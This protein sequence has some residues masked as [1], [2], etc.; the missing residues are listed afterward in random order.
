MSVDDKATPKPKD[1]WD[2]ILALS[3]LL[4]AVVVAALGYWLTGSVE[5]SLKLQ[6]LR[7]EATLKQQELQLS[8]VREMRELL[9]ELHKENASEQNVLASALT[10]S[11]FGRPAIGPLLS[12][13]SLD[14]AI[15]RQGAEEGLLA[16]GMIDTDK[17]CAALVGV[18]NNRSGRFRWL[19]HEGALRLIGELECPAD[20]ALP[21]LD[22][23]EALLLNVQTQEQLDDVA[24]VFLQQPPV[25][26]AAIKQL[27]FQLDRTITLA[28]R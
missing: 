11:A 9:M 3:P 1:A 15:R 14:D 16:I 25:D 5:N 7:Q 19:T 4:T 24:Y 18:I 8:N 23:F 12:I 2:K 10:L 22:Q 27:R 13:L 21:A 28:G 17:V 6:A 26:I 20:I